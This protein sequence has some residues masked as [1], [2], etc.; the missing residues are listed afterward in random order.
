MY[1]TFQVS[2]IN[3]F[4]F[5]YCVL[6]FF[7]NIHT[8]IWATKPTICLSLRANC[9][10]RSRFLCLCLLLFLGIMN[11]SAWSNRTLYIEILTR[12]IPDESSTNFLVPARVCDVEGGVAHLAISCF[13]GTVWHPKCAIVLILQ[14][15]QI[16]MWTGVR[17]R[18]S[19]FTFVPVGT[20]EF[21][22]KWMLHD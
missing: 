5:Y 14:H 4:N 17:M 3:S 13:D 18:F 12:Q 16:K 2:H 8:Q 6:V 11:P 7:V 21:T 9:F 19:P 10:S 15:Y 22:E 1:S 20:G